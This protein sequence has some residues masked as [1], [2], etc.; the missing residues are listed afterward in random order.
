MTAAQQSTFPPQLPPEIHRAIG[1]LTDPITILNLR[2]LKKGYPTLFTSTDLVETEADWRYFTRGVKDCCYWAVRNGHVWVVKRHVFELDSDTLRWMV[3]VA[4]S[5]SHKEVAEIIFSAGRADLVRLGGVLMA[6][7]EHGHLGIVKSFL[8][9]GLRPSQ[10]SVALDKAAANGHADVTKVLFRAGVSGPD[11][12][13]P[14]QRAAQGGHAGVVDVL[15]K[16]VPYPYIQEH[17]DDALDRAA[18]AGSAETIDLLL[19]AGADAGNLRSTSMNNAIAKGNVDVVQKLLAAG[20]KINTNVDPTMSPLLIAI[21]EGHTEMLKLLS[22]LR[23]YFQHHVATALPAAVE[24]NNVEMVKVLLQADGS[25]RCRGGSA[26]AIAAGEGH[27]EIVKY[28]LATGWSIQHHGLGALSA[29]V[30]NNK[31]EMVEF[32]LEGKPGFLMQPVASSCLDTAIRNGSSEITKVLLGVGLGCSMTEL[33]TAVQGNR[34]DIVKMLLEA[35]MQ[36]WDGCFLKDAAN[37]CRLLVAAAGKGHIGMVELLLDV[38]A[39]RLSVVKIPQG[40]LIAAS[41]AG[42]VGVV[43]LLLRREF[44]RGEG[45][46]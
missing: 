29:A 14:L 25:L 20:A 46:Q 12:M 31:I 37:R 2:R 3:M 9:S 45:G 8:A 42:H 19:R 35:D 28:L 39:E 41:K 11:L 13:K 22:S 23:I 34:I 1:K 32:L 40:A 5:E 18:T 7:A 36:Q 10:Y 6:A 38:Y 43:Q 26:L 15:L 16:A 4:L 24:R 17:L 21:R 33:V 44:A 27:I 30:Q